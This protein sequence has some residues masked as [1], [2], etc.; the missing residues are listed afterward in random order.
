MNCDSCGGVSAVL[1]RR[2]VRRRRCCL[3]CG[4]R[5]TTLEVRVSVLPPVLSPALAKLSK[6]AQHTKITSKAK[7]PKLAKLKSR[8]APLVDD[9]PELDDDVRLYLGEIFNVDD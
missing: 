1:E 6:L 2:G 4:R 3:A 5:W 9:E 8:P 7:N